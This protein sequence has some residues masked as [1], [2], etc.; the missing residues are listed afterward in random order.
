MKFVDKEHRDFFLRM[1][2]KTNSAK[3]PYREA[4]FYTL[5]LTGETRRNINSL[6]DF[7]E[8][9]INPD[10]MN[11][12]WQTSTSW[13]VTK[14]AFNLYNGYSGE[15]NEPSDY[16]PFEL[17]SCGLME[18]MFEAV[19]LLYPNYAERDEDGER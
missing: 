3:D 17:F 8:N 9:G 5:G 13:K 15:G 6:Y 18:Y 11:G 10:G 2:Y 16:T 14:L 12:G 1:V 4:L 19:R 7:K